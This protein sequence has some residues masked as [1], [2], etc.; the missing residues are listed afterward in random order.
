M[1]TLAV[2]LPTRPAVRRTAGRGFTLLEM[3]LVVVIMGLLVGVSVFGVQGY[4]NSARTATTK[5]EMTRI[6]QALET[7]NGTYGAYPETLEALA[8]GGTR[9]LDRVP[10]DGWKRPFVYTL[11]MTDPDRPY[12]LFSYGRRGQSGDASERIDIWTMDRN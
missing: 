11:N 9:Y 12:L 5:A 1:T 7:Y 3:M 4:I 6:K 8:S 10:T 2:R